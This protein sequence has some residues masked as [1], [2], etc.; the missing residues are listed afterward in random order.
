MWICRA[1]LLQ[2]FRWIDPAGSSIFNV[3]W[4][5]GELSWDFSLPL[6]GISMYVARDIGKIIIIKHWDC[7]VSALK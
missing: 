1:K 6:E 5:T 3:I 2:N 4:K 7:F